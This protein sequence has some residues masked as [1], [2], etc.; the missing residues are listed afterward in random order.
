MMKKNNEYDAEFDELLM[1]ILIRAYIEETKCQE[2]MF[3][4]I[5]LERAQRER[6]KLIAAIREQREKEETR[7]YKE[8]KKQEEQTRCLEYLREL[9]VSVN[10]IKFHAFERTLLVDNDTFSEIDSCIKAGDKIQREGRLTHILVPHND[11]PKTYDLLRVELNL[12]EEYRK[13]G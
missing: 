13:A 11:G 8:H 4:R 5:S 12:N 7:R 9:G 1:R 6:S 10:R 3:G 2:E